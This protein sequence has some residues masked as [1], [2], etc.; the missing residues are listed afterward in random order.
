[1]T[2]AVDGK[3]LRAVQC[4]PRASFRLIGEVAGVS[5]QTAARRFHALRRAGVMRV[6]GLIDPA[7]HGDA[8]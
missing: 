3:I 2:D 1:M 7:V 5:E 6:V 4:A 8:R